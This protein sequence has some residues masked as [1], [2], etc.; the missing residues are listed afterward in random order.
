MNQL[1]SKTVTSSAAQNGE[2]RVRNG[3][4][5]H[6]KIKVGKYEKLLYRWIEHPKRDKKR[7]ETYA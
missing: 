5:I 4:K 3:P 7:I 1:Y 6:P 2:K